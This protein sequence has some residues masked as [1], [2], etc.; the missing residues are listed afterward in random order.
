MQMTLAILAAMAFAVG[1]ILMKSADGL[2]QPLSVLGFIALFA[3][4]ASL[5]SLAMRSAELGATYILVLG[6]EAALA[7]AFGVLLFDERVTP[8][9]LAAV[10][11]IVA[12]IATLRTG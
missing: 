8:A 6:L 4:G 5:Q 3:A 1:G 10:G 9:R 11:L 2:R 12:G 7:F